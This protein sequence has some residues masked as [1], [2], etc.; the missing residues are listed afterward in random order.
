MN[1]KWKKMLIPASFIGVSVGLTYFLFRNEPD[2]EM[3]KEEKKTVDTPSRL[4][5]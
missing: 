3:L 2:K 4:I 5:Q 1:K